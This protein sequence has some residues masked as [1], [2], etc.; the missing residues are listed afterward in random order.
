MKGRPFVPVLGNPSEDLPEL[1]GVTW[2]VRPQQQVIAS[3]EQ[4][5]GP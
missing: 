2:P 5:G 4:V 3:G 1:L